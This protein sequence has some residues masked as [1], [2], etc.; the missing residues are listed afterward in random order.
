MIFLYLFY[1]YLCLGVLFGLYFVFAGAKKIDASVSHA[2]F[3]FK[4]IIL[5][6]SIVLWIYLLFKLLKK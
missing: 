4:L 2:P 3:S 5:P 1:I 6:A